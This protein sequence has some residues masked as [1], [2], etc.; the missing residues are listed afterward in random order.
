MHGHTVH[1]IK[2]EIVNEGSHGQIHGC[3]VH[4]ETGGD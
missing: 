3:H 2:I 4:A 1:A